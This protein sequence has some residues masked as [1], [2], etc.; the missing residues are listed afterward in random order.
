MSIAGDMICVVQYDRSVEGSNAYPN[1]ALQAKL[2][3]QE[4][5]LGAAFGRSLLLISIAASSYEF[6]SERVP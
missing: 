4:L 2:K 1:L 5:F 6:E 3:V